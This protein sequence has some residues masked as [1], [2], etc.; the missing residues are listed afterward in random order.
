MISV[1][2]RYW[3]LMPAAGVGKRFGA[4]RPKQYLELGTWWVIDYSLDLFLN[5]PAIAG[6]V[7]VLGPEDPYWPQGR[8]AHHARVH[9]A[10]G[11]AERSDSVANGL[12]CLANVLDA[13]EQDWVLVHD[14]ARPCLTREDLDRLLQV[15]N[16]PVAPDHGALLAVPL[17]DTVKRET[18]TLRVEGGRLIPVKRSEFKQDVSLSFPPMVAETLPREML[19]RAFTPQAFPLGLLREALARVRADGS[20]VTDD[21]SAVERLRYTPYL[22]SARSDNIKITR[23]ED[24]ALAAFYLEQQGRLC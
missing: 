3:V 10:T 15:L 7:V 5:H 8:F 13:A 1:D 18:P 20:A 17:H 11:G 24:L 16:S 21:A 4:E 14:A 9:R 22:I 23:P 19:W 12:E 6:V 2:A